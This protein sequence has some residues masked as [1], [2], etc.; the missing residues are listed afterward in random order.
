MGLP[1]PEARCSTAKVCQHAPTILSRNP[2]AART[3]TAS[4][5]FLI[6]VP[7]LTSQLGAVPSANGYTVVPAF[8]GVAFTEPVQIVFAPGETTRSFVVERAGRI[9]MIANIASP[10]RQVILDLSASVNQGDAGHGMLSMAFHP[11]FVQNGYFYVWTPIWISG[12]RYLQLLRFTLASNGTVAISSQVTLLS[13]PVGTGG[14]D[15][16]T[17][18]FGTDGYLYLSIGDG[19]EGSAG[20]EAIASHQRIDVGF[21]GGVFRFDVDQKAGNLL[22]NAHLGVVPTGYLVPADNPFVGATSFDGQPV[23][24]TQVRTEF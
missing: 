1:G 2:A 4:L 11:Q 6:L 7:S 23:N 5:A 8:G 15:G 19:D 9:A 22:P 12:L 18:L 14:H 3:W 16:G 24:P 20:A 21:F 10:S 13:Q 17:L